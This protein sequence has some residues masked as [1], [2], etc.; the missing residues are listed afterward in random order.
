VV[1]EHW[2]VIAARSAYSCQSRVDL[3]I[4]AI[5]NDIKQAVGYVAQVIALVG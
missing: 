4:G 2:P 5:I 3:D 1:A